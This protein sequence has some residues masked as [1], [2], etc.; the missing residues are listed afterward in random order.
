MITT[1][2]LTRRFGA[3]TALAGVTLEVPRGEMF[4]LIGPERR[5]ADHVEQARCP[6][7]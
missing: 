7:A 5:E 6:A 4:A 2:A 3:T 1:S